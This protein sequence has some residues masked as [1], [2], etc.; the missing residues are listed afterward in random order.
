MENTPHYSYTELAEW[1]AGKAAQGHLTDGRADPQKCGP[2]D[3]YGACSKAIAAA[4]HFRK[5][6]QEV[7]GSR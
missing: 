1:A 7:G 3:C 5:M 6:A 2:R 4:V